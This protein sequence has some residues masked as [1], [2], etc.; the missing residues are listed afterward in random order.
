LSKKKKK[1]K[2]IHVCAYMSSAPLAS[3]YHQ[4]GQRGASDVEELELQEIMT[5]EVGA[6][7]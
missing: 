3:R 1:K 6:E 7:K 4:G 5:P 2:T